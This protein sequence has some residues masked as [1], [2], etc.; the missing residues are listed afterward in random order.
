MNEITELE[1]EIYKK[2]KEVQ[3]LLKKEKR[4]DYLAMTIYED[5]IMFNNEYWC[6]RGRRNKIELFVQKDIVATAGG[7]EL[8]SKCNIK[9]ILENQ[10]EE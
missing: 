8:S 1:K 7:K 10:K 3:L 5:C 4:L 6:K 2:L 9:D